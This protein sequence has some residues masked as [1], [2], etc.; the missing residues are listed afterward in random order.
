MPVISTTHCDILDEVVQGESGLLTP[1]KDVI[2]LAQSIKRF[3][4]MKTSEY[5]EFAEYAR[6]HVE[7]NY[8]VRNSSEVLQ[9]IYLELWKNQKQKIH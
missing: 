6:Q 2:P 3:Y 9:K 5:M 8:D 1:E 7:K 4:Q